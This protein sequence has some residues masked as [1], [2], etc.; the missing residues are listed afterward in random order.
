MVSY[1]STTA[2][3]V[4]ETIHRMFP[5]I[6]LRV[7]GLSNIRRAAHKH[8]RTRGVF[9]KYNSNEKNISLSCATFFLLELSVN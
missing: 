2:C 7:F 3:R 1:L 4:S 9:T 6:T 5:F 8:A